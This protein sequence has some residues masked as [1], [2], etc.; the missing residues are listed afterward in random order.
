V[1]ESDT[2]AANILSIFVGS[3]YIELIFFIMGA[4][5]LKEAII[6]GLCIAN[7][8]TAVHKSETKKQK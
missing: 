8:H 5:L 6:P 4:L 2:S 7:M 1:V 3:H